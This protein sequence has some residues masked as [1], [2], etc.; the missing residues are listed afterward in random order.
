[1]LL[2]YANIVNQ[3]T[4]LM[5]DHKLYRLAKLR[6]TELGVSVGKLIEESLRGTLL[7]PL[8]RQKVP[9]RLRWKPFRGKIRSGIDL[10]DRKSLYDKM[11][12]ES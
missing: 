3:R 9:F 11:E 5:I 1:M 2:R 10:S 6:A 8:E 12:D 7:H 4:T